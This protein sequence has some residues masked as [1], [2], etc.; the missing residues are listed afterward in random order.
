M[1]IIHERNK[2]DFLGN[3]AIISV[4]LSIL[5][6]IILV[7]TGTFQDSSPIIDDSDLIHPNTI[8]YEFSH[9]YD[10]PSE[11]DKF[12]QEYIKFCIMHQSADF[13]QELV[14]QYFREAESFNS[15]QI[16]LRFEESYVGKHCSVIT[17]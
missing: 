9:Q 11:K 15:S 8:I 10:F 5:A 17:H 13:I 7:L 6:L 2:L 12:K 4:V 3:V 14:E 1:K 16:G